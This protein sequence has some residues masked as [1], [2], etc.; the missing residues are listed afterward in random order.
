MYVPK[1]RSVN[2]RNIILLYCLYV[3]DIYERKLF[4]I[5]RLLK[6]KT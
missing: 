5:A 2:L 4:A 3:C 6:K 1:S